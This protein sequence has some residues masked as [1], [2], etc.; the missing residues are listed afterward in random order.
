M[1]VQKTVIIIAGPT[2]VGKTSVAIQVAKHFD[3]EIISADSRQCYNEMNIG[4]ARPS[5]QELKEVRHHFIASH[6]IQ[7]KVTAAGFEQLALET[8]ENI[9]KEKSIAVMVGGTGLYIKAFCD[10]LDEIP[11]VPE[12]IRNAINEEYKKKGFVWLQ[13]KVKESDPKF[14]VEAEN[15]NPHR[16]MRALEVYQSTGI[17]IQEFKKKAKK[18]RT[19][20]TLKIALELLKEQLHQNINTR[21]DDMLKQGL[22]EE[23]RSLIPYK[24]LTAL[25]TV[26]YKELFDYFDGKI[27]LK[28]AVELIKQNTRQYA[29][30]QLTWFKKDKEF[31]WFDTYDLDKIKEHLISGSKV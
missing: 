21:V 14:F 8:A 10:G 20:T 2:A 5:E 9:L 1:P 11:E 28:H 12:A 4:V 3:T 23:V 13:Q 25:Q 16:L 30:R 31:E 18:K 26:G 15:Q 19:F 17:S 6:S 29:K 22:I 27:E 7:E 24:H